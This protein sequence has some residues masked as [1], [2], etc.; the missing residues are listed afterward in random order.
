LAAA[1]KTRIAVVLALVG[2]LLAVACSSSSDARTSGTNLLFAADDGTV[3]HGRVYGSGPTGVLLVH[4]FGSDQGVWQ[5]FARNLTDRGFMV[6][7]Y[8]MRGHGSS[9]GVREPGIA[10]ADAAAAMRYMR[11]SLSKEQLFLVGEGLGGI[12]ALKVASREKVLGVASI[13]SPAT[14]RG[15]TALNDIPRITSPKLFVA[16]EGDVDA[17]DAARAFQ[18]KA[19]DAEVAVFPGNAKGAALLGPGPGSAAKD[20][21][22][23]FLDANKPK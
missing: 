5:T 22:Q 17:K 18:E 3:L 12:A 20:K 19:K 8:D 11:K 15:V 9:P 6:L 21:V 23:Q 16:S 13:S 7:T 4:D 14:Y 10:D 1:P 2:A